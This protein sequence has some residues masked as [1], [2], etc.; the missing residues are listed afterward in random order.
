MD[1]DEDF[2][3]EEFLRDLAARLAELRRLKGYSQDRL[4]LEAGLTRGALSKIEKG[5]VDV[6]IS[7]LA[8]IAHTLGV[9]LP[10]LVAV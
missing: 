3:L 5:G 7:T 10:H 8:K 6:R 2:N 4:A 1:N 9:T